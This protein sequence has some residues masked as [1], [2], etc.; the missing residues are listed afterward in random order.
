MHDACDV[1]F[2][3]AGSRFHFRQVPILIVNFFEV[4]PAGDVIDDPLRD[5]GW[6]ADLRMDRAESSP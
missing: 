3:L 2:E 4:T 1:S 5:V 6:R